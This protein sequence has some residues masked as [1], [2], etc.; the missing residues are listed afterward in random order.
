[1]KIIILISTMKPSRDK[2]RLLHFKASSSNTMERKSFTTGDVC[3]FLKPWKIDRTIF[4]NR[5]RSPRGP[6]NPRIYSVT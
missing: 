1:M 2:S 4:V 5:L 3:S 6:M